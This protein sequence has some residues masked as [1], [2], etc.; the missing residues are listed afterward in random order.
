[1]LRSA[2]LRLS[3]TDRCNLRCVYCLPED[4]RFA[5]SRAS[6][7]ELMRLSELVS[8]A[9]PVRKVRITGG[10]P[11]LSDDLVAHVRHARTLAG[12]V[13]LTSNGVLLEPLLPALREAG[14]AKVNISLDALDAESFRRFSRRDGLE[15]VVAS[16]RAAK[17]LGFAPVKVNAVAMRATDYAAL[18]RFAAWEGIHLRF[19]ELMAIGEARSLRRDDYVAADEMRRRI[20]DAGISLTERVDRDEPTARV[21]AIDGHDADECS[22]GFITTVSAPFCATCDRIRLS[23]QGRFFT[24]L[25]DNQGVDLLAPLRA[26]DE[27][28]V[29]ERAR[30][31]VARKAPPTEFVRHEVMAAIG[32]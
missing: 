12:E 5:P 2:Y 29:V 4:A 22:V 18:V 15:R 11:T 10:E 19:I 27:D 28:A 3:I 1:M 9:V 31:A 14:L 30:E 25:M 26:G 24:C 16:I 13:G 21:W 17:R 7:A 32:G 8:R 23:S 20:F 6:A